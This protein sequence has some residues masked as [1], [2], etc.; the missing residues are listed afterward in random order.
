[1]A[2]MPTE[3]ERKFLGHLAGLEVAEEV[4]HDPRYV[5]SNLVNRPPPA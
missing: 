2:F 5:N 1:M 4:T 3:I